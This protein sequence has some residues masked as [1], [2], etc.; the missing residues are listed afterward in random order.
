MS[1]FNYIP[2][3]K[4]LK[5]K[6]FLCNIKCNDEMSFIYCILASL[7]PTKQDASR[8]GKYKHLL[9]KLNMEGID[10]PVSPSAVPIFEEQNGTSKQ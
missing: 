3:P 7:Y 8:S 4:T 5:G 1:C 6:R 10:C 2:T 9:K